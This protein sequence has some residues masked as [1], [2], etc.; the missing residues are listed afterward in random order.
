MFKKYF[1][2]FTIYCL[3]LLPLTSTLAQEF[4]R[5]SAKDTALVCVGRHVQLANGNYKYALPGVSIFTSFQGKSLDLLIN[6]WALGDASHTNYLSVIID[7]NTP[8]VVKLNPKDTVYTVTKT[9]ADGWHN[10]QIVKRTEGFVGTLEFMGIRIDKN[11]QVKKYQNLPAKK[12]LFIGNSITCGYGNDTSIAAEPNTG[13]KAKHEDN[14]NTY[15]QITA[16][17]LNAQY[18]AFAYS[19][20][21]LFKNYDGS[22]T[23]TIPQIINRVIPD[24]QT[25]VW[26]AK[27]YQPEIIFS[28]LGTNDFSSEAQNKGYIDS[29]TFCTKYHEFIAN[30]RKDYPS[31][32][33]VLLVGTMMSDYWPVGARQW[34]RIQSYTKAV[35]EQENK[36][37]NTNVYFLALTPQNPP[38]GDDWHPTVATHQKM[39]NQLV[40]FIQKN[41]LF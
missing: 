13:F 11:A 2:K 3:P 22:T 7:Q 4:K 12:L 9:L 27:N 6:D 40:D 20:R 25:Y 15:G 41:K 16:R 26:N 23:N 39:A 10:V 34:T 36:A 29:V 32:K 1:L 14:Y 33:I 5:V 38:Y 35:A 31:S 17:T 19:G 30:L 37:G 18:H 28:N 8:I 21:G 24:E